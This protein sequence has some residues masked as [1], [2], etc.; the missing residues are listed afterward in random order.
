MNCICFLFI[1]NQANY[2]PIWLLNK[3]EY[4]HRW[5]YQKWDYHSFPMIKRLSAIY[6]KMILNQTIPLETFIAY[7]TLPGFQYKKIQISHDDNTTTHEDDYHLPICLTPFRDYAPTKHHGWKPN[8]QHAVLICINHPDWYIQVSC[9]GRLVKSSTKR[10][11]A[12]Q[13]CSIHFPHRYAIS[14]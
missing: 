14:W 4:V 11:P 13:H 1:S 5:F 12:S 3:Q 6:G 2:Y 7:C 10:A 8:S 9:I